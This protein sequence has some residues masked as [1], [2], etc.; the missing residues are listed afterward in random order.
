VVVEPADQY[1]RAIE[2]YL[3]RKNDGHLIR[4]VGPAFEQVL[5][6]AAKGVP[7]KIACH[8]IDRYFERY[9]AKG[10]RRRPVRIEFCEADVLDAFDEWR[11]AVGIA[12]DS[13]LTSA[14][15]T[16]TGP[17][18]ET[19]GR[20]ESLPAHLERVIA[21]LTA[22]RAGADRSLDGILDS[23][24]RE[25]DARRTEAKS[26]R[27]DARRAFVDRL[28]ALD[29]ELLAA[30]RGQCDAT[31]LAQL[32]SEAEEELAPFRDRLASAAFADARRAAT[33]R[34]LRERSRLPVIAF[35]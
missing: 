24:I 33:D 1:C 10:P 5:G 21:R 14:D 15:A 19:T 27:G 18:E 31:T 29:V 4:I 9:Y 12:T 28:G 8:G 30:V 20:H 11:R 16:G 13:R 7:L 26:L 32:G 23:V 3:C 6:W 17:S 34:L 2:A 22:L 25:L 35:D